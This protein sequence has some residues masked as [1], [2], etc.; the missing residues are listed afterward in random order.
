MH[1]LFTSCPS[2]QTLTGPH[3]DNSRISKAK[4][5]YKPK[6]NSPQLRSISAQIMWKKL[7]ERN[8]NRFFPRYQCAMRPHCS[9]PACVFQFC[10]GVVKWCRGGGGGGKV[11]TNL[12]VKFVCPGE[13]GHRDVTKREARNFEE[14]RDNCSWPSWFAAPSL[15]ACEPQTHF[16]SS[17]LSLRKIASANPSDKTISVT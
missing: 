7:I 11:D 12:A 6:L 5:S 14:F 2:K 4:L 17:L 8:W 3:Q 10:L 1:A 13:L 15:I 9:R 16:R